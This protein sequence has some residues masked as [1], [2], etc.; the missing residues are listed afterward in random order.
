MYSSYSKIYKYLLKN[1]N[2]IKLKKGCSKDV[3]WPGNSKLDFV[4]LR[5]H[6]ENSAEI[7]GKYTDKKTSL[8]RIEIDIPST[9][10]KACEKLLG[11]LLG[12]A[13]G[14]ITKEYAVFFLKNKKLPNL[15]VYRILNTDDVYIE[16]EGVSKSEVYNIYRYLKKTMPYKTKKINKSLYSIYFHG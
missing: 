13:I 16:I 5:G 1:S 3:Y 10:P 11:R 8:N 14:S 4:R 2:F 15:S 12:K 6:S 9:D 7:T